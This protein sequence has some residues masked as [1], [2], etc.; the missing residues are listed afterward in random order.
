MQ[1][2]LLELDY[3]SVKGRAAPVRLFTMIEDSGVEDL[4]SFSVARQAY[5]EGRF[6]EAREMFLKQK[7]K[8]S[9]FFAER[10][11]M[12]VEENKTWNGYYVWGVK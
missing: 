3:A 12:L 1:S 8:L 9:V 10:C 6:E 2:Q 5:L 4:V 7:G 11:A